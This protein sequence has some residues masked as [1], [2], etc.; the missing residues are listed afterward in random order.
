MSV[1][2]RVKNYKNNQK[3]ENI[4]LFNF[5]IFSNLKTTFTEISH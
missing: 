3:H 2:S 1:M 5:L 4:D